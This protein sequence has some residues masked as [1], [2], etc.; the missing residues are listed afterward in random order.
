V[1]KKNRKALIEAFTLEQRVREAF[2]KELLG[3]QEEA[4]IGALEQRVR[5]LEQFP[6]QLLKALLAK[7]R[8]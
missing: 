8:T 3:N 7:L 5:E 1:R 2:R 4:S 6:D